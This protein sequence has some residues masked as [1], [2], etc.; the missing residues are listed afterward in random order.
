MLVGV[1]LSALILIMASWSGGSC[2]NLRGA[3]RRLAGWRVASACD[4]INR[5]F[6][7]ETDDEILPTNQ[8]ESRSTV[9]R[10]TNLSHT[11]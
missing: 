10:S 2:P 6:F 11:R 7:Q 3:A 9:A 4:E 1:G 5:F 8:C